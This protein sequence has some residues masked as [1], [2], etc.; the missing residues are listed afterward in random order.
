M[1]LKIT[2]KENDKFCIEI[3]LV[4]VLNENVLLLQDTVHN[5]T[6]ILIFS[7]DSNTVSIFLFLKIAAFNFI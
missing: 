4:R 2:T 5:D 7:K 6:S 1:R 3:S